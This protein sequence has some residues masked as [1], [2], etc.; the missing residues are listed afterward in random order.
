[1]PLTNLP[2]VIVVTTA[3]AFSFKPVFVSTCSLL[4]TL[5]LT[6]KLA[7]TATV[8]IEVVKI[9]TINR[10]VSNYLVWSDFGASAP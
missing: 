1:M 5:F 4:K 9:P 2:H 7:T 6:K 8:A 10:G 3:L